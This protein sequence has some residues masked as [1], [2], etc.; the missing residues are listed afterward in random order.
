MPKDNFSLRLFF[1]CLPG[2]PFRP[3]RMKIAFGGYGKSMDIKMVRQFSFRLSSVMKI[4]YLSEKY[5]LGCMKM[6]FQLEIGTLECREMA[7]QVEIRDWRWWKVVSRFEIV[8]LGWMKALYESETVF[9]VFSHNEMSLIT[10]LLT[11]DKYS[12]TQLHNECC[13]NSPI[14]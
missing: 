10:L 9:F 12:S 11:Q 7:F 4:R 5:P 6:I 1:F 14:Q 13:Y 2:D 3:N 8:D